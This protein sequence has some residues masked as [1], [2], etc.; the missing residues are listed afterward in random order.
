MPEPKYRLGRLNGRFVVTH[1]EEAADGTQVRRR[2]RLDP[3]VSKTEALQRLESLKL[4]AKSSG[5]PNV[6]GLWDLYCSKN[7]EKR[8]Y[9][10]MGFER[11]KIM[12]WFGHLTEHT[13]KEEVCEAYIEAQRASGFHDGTIWTELGHL[14]TVLKWAE[15]RSYINKAPVIKRPSKP[16]P[17][18]RWLT[19][20]EAAHLIECAENHHLKLAL[21]LMLSTAGRITA[22]LELT[23]DRVDMEKRRI[24]LAL[25]GAARKKGRATVPINDTAFRFLQ[26]ARPA[27]LSDNVIEWNGS[28]VKSL[29]TAYNRARDKAN[30]SPDF[31]F[32]GVS[33]HT[34]RHTAAVWMVSAGVAMELVSQYLGHTSIDV[35][36]KTY[37]RYA[38]ESMADAGA[39]L[40]LQVQPNS[41]LNR[42]K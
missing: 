20:E 32:D 31:D 15:A 9:R 4:A 13:L 8:V 16:D 5:A 26:E 11:K 36:R 24:R 27:A 19:R 34:L 28:P 29:K 41:K 1:H 33:P 42:K 25:T 10:S 23:W 21:V 12:P 39:V 30:K 37:A 3:G 2:Y 7:T 22:I 6:E 38:P 14:R 17:K 40:D 18:D 35:T